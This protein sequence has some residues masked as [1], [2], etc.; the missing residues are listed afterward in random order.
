MFVETKSNYVEVSPR[1]PEFSF[2]DGPCIVHR[3]AI[4]IDNRCPSRYITLLQQAIQ[5]GWIEPV[6]YLKENEYLW[7]RLSQVGDAR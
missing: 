3:A 2:V 7:D 4:K 5:N 6:A 1:D